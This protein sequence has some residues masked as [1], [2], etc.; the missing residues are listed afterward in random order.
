M[1]SWIIDS[2]ISV[3]VTKLHIDIT[4]LYSIKLY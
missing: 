4:K 2:K 3:A 1:N